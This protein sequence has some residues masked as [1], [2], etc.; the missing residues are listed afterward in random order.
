MTSERQA[1]KILKRRAADLSVVTGI[2]ASRIESEMIATELTPGQWAQLHGLDPMT[3]EPRSMSAE[4]MATQAERLWSRMRLDPAAPVPSAEVIAEVIELQ[5]TFLR[6]EWYIFQSGAPM[7]ADL[8]QQDA[9]LVMLHERGAGVD[10][11]WLNAALQRAGVQEVPPLLK[12]Q[13][14]EQWDKRQRRAVVE[15]RG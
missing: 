6:N 13:T 7:I 11:D 12:L 9:L 3:F 5:E 1:R 10:A 14:R 15:R 2:P 8:D 4:Q